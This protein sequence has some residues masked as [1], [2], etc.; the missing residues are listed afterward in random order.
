M[1][2]IP[3][4]AGRY[5]GA[6]KYR[7]LISNRLRALGLNECRTYTLVS[8][9]EVMQIFNKIIEDVTKKHNAVLRDK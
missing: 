8:D 6:V 1:P 3:D 9:E 5:V 4:R 2:I 7:K